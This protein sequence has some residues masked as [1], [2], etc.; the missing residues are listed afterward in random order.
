MRKS[1]PLADPLSDAVATQYEQWVYPEPITDLAQWAAASNCDAVDPQ[2]MHLAYWL[3]GSFREDLR[4]LV[5]GCGSNQA[6]T[7]A[8]TNPQAQVVGIDISSA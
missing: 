8:F 1:I 6:A 2:R 3:D 7:L 4:I 5:A